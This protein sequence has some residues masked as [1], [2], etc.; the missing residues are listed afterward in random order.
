MEWVEAM[1]VLY[2]RWKHFIS[3]PIARYVWSTFQCAFDSPM[4]SRSCFEL[5][6]WVDK[7]KETKKFML[8]SSKQQSFDLFGK[9]DTESA[10]IIYCLI[11]LVKSCT[12]FITGLIIGVNCRNQ[13]CRKRYDKALICWRWWSETCSTDRGY[14]HRYVEEYI[15]NNLR[16]SVCEFEEYIVNNLH[17]SVCEFC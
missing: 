6:S 5:G 12:R 17:R 3:C 14:E 7:F 16:Q 11:I 13:R 2:I 8:K 4:Q 1:H 9:L 10:L 15:V